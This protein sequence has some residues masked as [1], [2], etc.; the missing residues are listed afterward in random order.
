MDRSAWR[1]NPGILSEQE[2]AW[3]YKRNL[4]PIREGK[5]G[6]APMEQVAVTP[7]ETLRAG[8]QFMDLAGDGLPDS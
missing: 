4:S 2:G 5:A 6:F 7:S 3:F 8:A 1:G